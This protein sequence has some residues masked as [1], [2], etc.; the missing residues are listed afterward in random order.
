MCHRNQTHQEQLWEISCNLLKDYLSRDIW[1][2]YGP[3]E[4]EPRG[5]LEATADGQGKDPQGPLK[6]TDEER[7]EE[8]AR[9]DNSTEEQASALRPP[10]ETEQTE[11]NN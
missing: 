11:K 10:T 7:G 6:S 9:G 1:R 5:E 2:E 8:T 4:V 3:Q